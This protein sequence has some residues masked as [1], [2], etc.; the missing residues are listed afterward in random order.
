MF[1]EALARL[2]AC[3]CPGPAP[4]GIASQ[5]RV[6]WAASSGEGV[7]L[8]FD[9]GLA[10]DY[11]P[12]SRTP[13]EYGTDAAAMI[14]DDAANG[15]SGFRL[16][17]VRGVVGMGADPDAHGPGALTWVTGRYSV[18]MLTQMLPGRTGVQFSLD[19]LLSIAEQ[20]Q[21]PR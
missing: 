4:V 7:G 12:D 19:D 17:T 8:M 10:L 11:V 18:R 16:V 6:L 1:D 2:A 21:V 14:A 15:G 20:L 3:G 13:E 9:S 5:S